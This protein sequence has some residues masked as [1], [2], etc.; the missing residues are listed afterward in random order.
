MRDAAAA[1]RKQIDWRQTFT[2]LKYPNYRLWFY[3]QMTSLFGTWMQSTAQGYLVYQLTH[4]AAYLG[5]VSFAGGVPSWLLMLYGGVIAD[6][7]PRRTLLIVTQTAM[8]LLAFTLAALTFLGWVM[9]WHII[10]LAFLLGV[11][12]AFDAPARLSFVLELVEREDLTNAVAL[13]GTMFNTAQAIGPAAAGLAYAAVGP[14]W[15]FLL[16]GVSYI[17]VI[18]ALALMKIRRTN[19]HVRN[20]SAI[21]DIREGLAYV[22]RQPIIVALIVLQGTVNL[23]GVAFITLMPAW[24][25]RVLGGNATTVG[26]LQSARG[27]GALVVALMIAALGRFRFRGRLISVG[28]LAFPLATGLFAAMR[29]LPLALAA[30]LV[31]GGTLVLMGNL[32]NSLV[33]SLSADELRGR[34]TGIYTLVVFGAGPLCGLWAGSVAQRWGEPV[35]VYIGAGVTLAVAL[36]LYAF[37]PR[38]RRLP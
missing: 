35:A 11:A 5:Y 17:A 22:A 32:A 9:P 30:Q 34:V 33:Q 2:C 7:V 18:L 13:N 24:A 31:V 28:A 25:V 6:R 8:M 20:A 23:F 21:H 19:V 3:G 10:A 26:L 36:G 14:A 29:W 38:L 27:V 15:C 4:S 16:N 12:T 1:L 37:V